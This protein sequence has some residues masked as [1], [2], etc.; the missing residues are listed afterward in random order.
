MSI[1]SPARSRW[2]R[3]LSIRAARPPRA[4]S[5]PRR[6]PSGS[7]GFGSEPTAA[8]SAASAAASSSVSP[9]TRRETSCIS[10]IAPAASSPAF[11]ACAIALRG[12]VLARAQPLDLRQQLAPAR[13]QR[14]RLVEPRVRAVAAPGQRRAHRVGVP[15]D[16]LQV[17]HSGASGRFGLVRLLARVLRDEARDRLGL[18][19][20]DDVLRHRAGG[21]AAVA[22]RVEDLVDLLLA[23]VEVRAVLVLALVG[24]LGR[25]LG[26][27]RRRA[28]GSRRSA[29]GRSPRRRSSGCP[30][31][32]RSPPS[33][34]RPRPRPRPE[35]RGAAGG[36]A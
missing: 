21:E 14:Q 15:P 27:R 8:S 16:R 20:D 24:D 7:G 34:R 31:R 9:L 10:A 2:S 22:D 11:F 18:L 23:L 6:P 32:P 26:A 33:R 19:A 25:A 29:G 5:R 36:G 17:E 12:L 28:S 35:A 30:R 1:S 3:G 4:A 13:V